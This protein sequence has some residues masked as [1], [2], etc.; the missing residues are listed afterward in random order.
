LHMELQEEEEEGSIMGLLRRVT[1]QQP[2]PHTTVVVSSRLYNHTQAL[3]YLP[4]AVFRQLSRRMTI[5]HL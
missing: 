3:Q 1:E 2:F 4:Q 5:L